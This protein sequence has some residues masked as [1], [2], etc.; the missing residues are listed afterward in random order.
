MTSA[1]LDYRNPPPLFDVGTLWSTLRR[2]WPLIV[3]ITALVVLGATGYLLVTK[4]SYTASAA[5][6]VDPRDIKTTNIDSV[7]PGIGADSAAI[8]SQVSVI[9]SR[10]LLSQVFAS[11]HLETD[12]EYAASSGGGLLGFLKPAA[13]PSTETVFQ[14]FQSAVSVE[15]E[16]LTYVID[17]A[18]KSHDAAKAARIANAVVEQ[19]IA[20]QASQS[21][22]AN[23]DV[24]TALNARIAVL[25]T[26]VSNAEQAVEAFKAKNGIYD[27]TTGGTLQS[28]VDALSAQVLAAQDALNQ[29]QVKVD[30]ASAA[31]TSPSALLQ[32]SDIWS[33]TTMDALRADYNQRAATLASDQATMGPKHPTVVRAQAEVTKVQ[34]LLAR[35]AGRIVKQLKSDRALAAANLDKLTAS[36]SDL[37]KRSSQSDVAAVG[38]RQLQRQADAARA[39]LTD[40]MQRS[41][42]TSQLPGLQSSQ[43]HV[44]SS[45][46]PPADPT[47]PKPMLILPVSALLGV[48]LGCGMALLLGDRAPAPAPL[49]TSPDRPRKAVRPPAR[50]QVEAFR[51]GLSAARRLAGLD[52][53][54][55]DLNTGTDSPLSRAL[56]DVLRQILADLPRQRKPFLIAL[57]GLGDPALASFGAELLALGLEHIGG[58]A[59]VAG[60][61]TGN[62]H[63]ASDFDFILA[64]D[65]QSDLAAHPDLS[66][67]VMSADEAEAWDAAEH[68]GTINFVIDLDAP[69]AARPRIAAVAPHE[70]VLAAG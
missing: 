57:S 55:R 4:P 38:L 56:Q 59:L 41:Q 7:L 43:V 61:E 48:L 46:A 33:S 30:Q 60:L 44:I 40:F 35:E 45:A 34:G 62:Q 29:A 28:Q 5:I 54:R 65:G 52:G 3:G 51:P 9:Q 47:W 24:T 67:L 23:T 42:E 66:V 63:Q 21:T 1:S 37:R 25:Q 10:E 2:R 17:V 31:G 19:Y 14:K 26:D 68:T 27:T 13:A 15:R 39:V 69:P 8:A 22:T 36:L 64:L 12:P 20:R 49:P 18:V 6:L 50:G 70:P 58:R 16:G 11:L 53:V 32:L